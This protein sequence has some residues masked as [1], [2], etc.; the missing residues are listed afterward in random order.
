[1]EKKK[2]KEYHISLCKG[3]VGRYVLLTGDPGRTPLI[4]KSFDGVK[5]MAFNREYRTFTGNITG[6]DGEKIKISTT[7]T[8]IGCPST[9]IAIEEL[10]KIGADTFIKI[11]TA[12]SLQKEVLLGDI[13]I[14]TA[15]VREE[16]T[17]RQYIPLSY[18]AVANFDV[19]NA[20]ISA[21]KKLKIATHVGISH[22][23]DAFYSEGKSIKS[24][25]IFTH[26]EQMWAA[27]YRSNVL[28]TSMESAA[29]FVV[30][31]IRKVYAGEVLTVIGLTYSNQPI[32]KKVGVEKAIKIAIESVKILNQIRNEILSA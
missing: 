10:I 16:G 11:G 19:T 15:A 24:L 28:A 31:S 3:D 6:Y 29:L 26:N 12:G 8:G 22:C 14:S 5:E 27:W 4:A 25:P 13:V 1:M 23:K 20:L 21:A 32:I 17:T 2:E 18:P 7:S 9:A 30:C